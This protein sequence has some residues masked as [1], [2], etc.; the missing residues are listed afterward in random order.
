[1]IFIQICWYF[2]EPC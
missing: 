1:M 2:W